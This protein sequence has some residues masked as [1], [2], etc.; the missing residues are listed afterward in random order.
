MKAEK[1]KVIIADDHNLYRT[2]LR[3]LLQEDDDIE[4]IAEASNGRDL[5]DLAK[6][7]TP[8]IVLTDLIM[9]GIDGVQAIKELSVIPGIQ[10]IALSTFDSEN[11]IVKALEAGAR[12]YIIKN[13]QDGEII[14]AIKTVHKFSPYYCRSTESR[15]VRLI[16]KSNFN[17]YSKPKPNLFSEREKDVIRLVCEEK[18]SEEI[19][20]ILFMS[21]R[22]VDGIRAK[23]LIKMNV[24]TTAGVAIYA[25]KNSIYILETADPR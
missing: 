19:G 1:I 11:L 5:I 2:G 10:F 18:S 7:Y 9:P 20:K 24:K 25:I 21:K 16:A 17:P 6:Q 22:T 13:A 8:D 4:I 14:D 12:G 3:M 23:I 15:L